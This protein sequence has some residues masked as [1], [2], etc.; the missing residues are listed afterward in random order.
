MATLE[1]AGSRRHKHSKP[2][3]YWTMEHN[4]EK[5]DGPVK[6]DGG[7]IT[8][9]EQAT[10]L[11][12]EINCLDI[13][14]IAKI[15]VE[16]IPKILGVKFASL[17]I[18]NQTNKILHLQKCNHPFLINKIVSLN[19]NPP[20]PMIMAVASK[21]LILTSDIDTHKRPIIRKSQR[22]FADNYETSNCAITPLIC[23]NNVVGVLNLADK[24]NA[25]NFSSEDIALIKLFS[26]LAGASIGNIKMFEKI[27]H[28][29]TT[30][31]LTGLANHKRFYEILEQELWRYRR[32][33]GHV[34]LI[35][36]DID[37]LKNTNDS[38]GHR[39]GDKVIKEISRKIKGCIRQ[40]DIAARYGG[41]EFAVILPNTAINDAVLVAE[42]MVDVV[43][44]STITW[45]RQQIGLSISV[46]LGEYGPESSPEDI[47]S[48]SDEALYRAKQAGKNTVRVFEQSPE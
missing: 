48:R 7:S 25:G 11:A 5:N 39:A 18:L 40:I 1:V 47:T 8:L 32:Y 26:Q 29:A 42:R 28:Q 10:P 9:L 31:G 3:L 33:G 13:E 44:N 23:Q 2:E 21:E 41:D 27:Q 37:N 17:Y 30:D 14:R 38:F 20:S 36:V 15:C 45:K 43:S 22:T 19:Q 24:I 16:D 35:M 34:S 4:R 6:R 46:G 12:Q